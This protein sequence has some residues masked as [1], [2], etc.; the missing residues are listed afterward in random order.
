MKRLAA[1]LLAACMLVAC[2]DTVTQP[3]PAADGSILTTAADAH[4]KGIIERVTGS[5][6]FETQP[7]AL[8]PGIW[9]TFTMNAKKKGDGSVTG[10]AQY[11]YH[12]DEGEDEVFRG[13]IS[14]FTI[15][16]NRVW[17]GGHQEGV[18]PSD[19][20]FQ[21]EDN[22]EGEGDP[23]GVGLWIEAATFGYEAGFAEMFCE[24][25]PEELDFGPFGV[26]PVDVV[27]FPIVEGNIQVKV[28]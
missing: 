28:K 18:E 8:N 20:A 5:G 26:L 16:D 17:I 24:E 11:V 21:V 15:I 3:N 14:C 25:T 27:L 1:S 22:G 13:T 23:D 9:R 6:H 19:F 4:A 12:P 2:S 10:Y 7:P